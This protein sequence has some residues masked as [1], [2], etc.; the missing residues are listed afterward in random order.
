MKQDPETEFVDFGYEKI[1][2][3]E[4]NGRVESVFRSISARYDVMNDLM[5][6]G[7][8]RIFKR[9]VIEMSATRPGDRVLDLAGGTGDLAALFVPVVGDSGQVVLAD[10]NAPMME[11]GR[12]Q[13][14]NKGVSGVEFCQANAEFLPFAKASFHCISMGFGL[15]NVTHKEVALLEMHRV[16]KPGGRLLILEFSKP[17]NKLVEAGYSGFQALWP[18]FGKLITGDSGPYSYLVESIKV[19]PNQQALKQMIEDAGF[20]TVQFHNLL[21]GI[22]SIHRATKAQS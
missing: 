14:L 6:L 17:E 13:L 8:H 7:M 9:M 2:A 20:E 19:H 3:S 11:V 5:S 18:A 21:N 12:D 10:I 4:K 16:L 15:R 22:V 1:P